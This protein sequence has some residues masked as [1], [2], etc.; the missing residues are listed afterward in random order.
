MQEMIL[1]GANHDSNGNRAAPADRRDRRRA[2]RKRSSQ[3]DAMARMYG[4]YV[5][6]GKA[7]MRLG[8]KEKHNGS[9]C[10]Y[11]NHGEPSFPLPISGV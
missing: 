1:Q 3:G 9:Q 10:A 7:G 11:L 8:V 4:E 2:H 6:I 5:N